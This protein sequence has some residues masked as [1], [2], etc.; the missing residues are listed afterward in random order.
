MMSEGGTESLPCAPMRDRYKKRLVL[1]LMQPKLHAIECIT[2]L[3]KYFSILIISFDP[4]R[5]HIAS[6][7]RKYAFDFQHIQQV[8]FC[9][10]YFTFNIEFCTVKVNLSGLEIDF[11]KHREFVAQ[12]FKISTKP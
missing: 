10:C 1:P 3:I 4:L 6:K 11:K 8:V 9:R 12:I 2:Q 7:N 5:C